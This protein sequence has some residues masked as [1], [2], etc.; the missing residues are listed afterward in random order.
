MPAVYPGARPS[1][2][3][4]I[5]SLMT[6]GCSLGL[7]FGYFDLL[8]KT[9]HSWPSLR[10]DMSLA[11]IAFSVFMTVFL[12]IAYTWASREPSCGMHSRN[13]AP[14]TV[15]PGNVTPCPTLLLA[16]EP[17]C[18]PLWPAPER[19]V[20]PALPRLQTAVGWLHAAL[21]LRPGPVDSPVCGRPRYQP[22]Q[23][24]GRH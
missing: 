5:F 16:A 19:R 17:A 7:G 10:H 14:S 3:P 12:N 15:L 23:L 2:W 1:A 20:P 24:P 4:T 9:S 18:R 13:I 21:C 8:W 11:A 6:V 22:F